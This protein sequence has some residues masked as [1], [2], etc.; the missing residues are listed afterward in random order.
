M[1]GTGTPG[2]AATNLFFALSFM[3]CVYNFVRAATLDAGIVP[4]VQNSSQ[5][6]EVR[7]S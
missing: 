7:L 6:K 3:I 1:S 5:L 4:K 2:Y